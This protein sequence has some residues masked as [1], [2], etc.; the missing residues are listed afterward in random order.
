LDNLALAERYL[1]GELR[2]HFHL[3]HL[4]VGH[5]GTRHPVEYCAINE[6]VL[7]V[8]DRGMDRSRHALHA[9][10]EV[11]GYIGQTVERA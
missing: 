8:G 6:R 10:L 1:K 2:I 11:G 9:S 7:P 5:S 3:R 4:C